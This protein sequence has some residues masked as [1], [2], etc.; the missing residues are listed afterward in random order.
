RGF[1]LE[2]RSNIANLQGHEMSPDSARPEP[3]LPSLGATIQMGGENPDGQTSEGL[4]LKI[5]ARI[6]EAIFHV[7]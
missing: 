2:V 4:W 5:Q 3:A 1:G 7:P 6:G